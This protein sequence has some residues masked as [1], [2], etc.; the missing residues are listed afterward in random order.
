MEHAH[1]LQTHSGRQ[2]ILEL[3]TKNASDSNS[4]LLLDLDNTLTDTRRWF[5]DTILDLT[6]ELAA[7]F[8]VEERI[9]NALFAEVAAATTL[10]EY[11]FVVEI[12][13]SRLSVHRNLTFQQI[14]STAHSF[15]RSFLE[16]H[17]SIELYDGVIETLNDIR[18][19]HPQ[20]KIVILTD[21]PEWIALERLTKIGVLPLIDGLI[22]IRTHTPRLRHSGYQSCIASS[23]QRMS[24]HQSNFDTKH[25][26]FNLSVPSKFA[27]PSSAGIELAAQRLGVTSGQII[28]VGD[29]DTKEGQAAANWRKTPSAQL[30][31]NSRIHYVRAEYGNH[32]INHQRY[33][34]LSNQISSLKIS[35]SLRSGEVE[36]HRSIENFKEMKQL[37]D[38][39]IDAGS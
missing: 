23:L 6:A 32:D 25:L 27:K 15:W 7:E 10:H 16:R 35:R 28:I 29:K 11:A 14:K 31:H 13:A 37:L 36:V 5:A 18:R 19:Q 12:I 2:A 8:V 17:E 26:L 3:P 38:E 33:S 21:S 22:A 9:V 24:Q 39:L 30:Y 34:K 1:L 20:L 4:L